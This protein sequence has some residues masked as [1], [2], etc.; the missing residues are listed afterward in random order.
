MTIKE[1]RRTAR[2]IQVVAEKEGKT[3]E[4]VRQAMQEAIDTAWSDAW[5]PGN[6]RA[7]AEWQR[8]FWGATRPSVEEFIARCSNYVMR[9]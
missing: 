4:E 2:T 9:K 6:I 5:R 3:L 8:L 1:K 7:Q